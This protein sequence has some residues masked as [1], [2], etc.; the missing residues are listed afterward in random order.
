MRKTE[1]YVKKILS[2]K[3][4]ETAKNIKSDEAAKKIKM[5]ENSNINMNKF[6]NKKSN[7]RIKHKICVLI[8]IIAMLGLTGCKFKDTITEIGDLLGLPISGEKTEMHKME[9]DKD[10]TPVIVFETDDDPVIYFEDEVEEETEEVEEIPEEIEEEEIWDDENKIYT[11]K[12][13][14]KDQ[15]ILDFI[16][17]VSFSD[18]YANMGVL[19]EK[20]EGIKGVLSSDVLNEFYSADI[21]MMNNE[22]PYSDKGSAREGKK[23]TFRARPETVSYLDDM[24][25]DIVA[26][27]NNHAYDYGPEALIDT[28]DILYENKVPFVGAG[29]NIEEAKKPVYFKTNNKTIAYVAAT[30]IERIAS[31][32]TKEATED[33]PGVLRTLDATKFLGVIA[34]AEENSDFVVVYVHWGSENTDLVEDGQKELA[35]KY[36][37]AGADLIIGD[38]SH[39][40]QGIDYIDGVPVIYS[41][42]NFWFNSRT[43]DTCIFQT[44]LDTSSENVT[45]K[46]VK[47]IPCQQKGC[48]THLSSAEEMD[49]I[50]SYMQGISYHA[51]I[52]ENG[53]VTETSEN[54]NTQNGMNTCPNKVTEKK[55]GEEVPSGDALPVDP[56][57][58]VLP[59]AVQ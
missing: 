14:S 11:K 1:K 54:L 27:A 29:K 16:G 56:S 34:E 40:L 53:Y 45:I 59:D 41:L 3:S 19:R 33:S 22:F 57:S 21:L 7:I 51:K 4:E 23:F 31:P 28:I 52:D 44:I 50:I 25:V 43:V 32:D 12:A 37:D 35:K 42:G 6:T 36:I 18:G 30:Q 26:L 49:H 58:L 20:G 55:E 8:C 46:S 17:D 47:F 15:V 2:I 39:C 13:Q 38:H 5:D 48:S 9:I 24:S 10:D